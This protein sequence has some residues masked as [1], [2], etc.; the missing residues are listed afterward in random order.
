MQSNYF[1]KLDMT[2]SG[3][4]SSGHSDFLNYQD[5]ANN[6][7][8]A[9]TGVSLLTATT[10]TDRVSGNADL[11]LTYHFTRN[12]SVSDKFRWLD[13]RNPGNSNQTGFTCSARCRSWLDS[14]H[15]RLHHSF[16]CRLILL[17]YWPSARIPTRRR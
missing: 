4:Y 5:F 11:G 7:N 16:K 9:N 17:R 10:H 14:S 15:R 3:T 12:W 2:A 13:W 6:R 8:N 1:R